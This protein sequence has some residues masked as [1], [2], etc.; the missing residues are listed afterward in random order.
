MQKPKATTTEMKDD[1]KI[2][3]SPRPL[4]PQPR[5]IMLRP[6]L[7]IQR[8]NP[9]Y[10]ISQSEKTKAEKSTHKWNINV[11][12]LEDSSTIFPIER[13]HVILKNISAS[14]VAD[15]VTVC[16]E[17]NSI[18]A[19]FYDDEAM[20]VAETED[21]TRFEIRLLKHQT[22]DKKDNLLLE[23]QRKSGSTITFHWAA[24]SILKS[25]QGIAVKETVPRPLAVSLIPLPLPEGKYREQIAV[26]KE[27]ENIE[28]LLQKD[29]LDANVLGMESLR[30]LTS[31]LS[32]SAK[33]AEI[34]SR[35]I[36]YNEEGNPM[37]GN[38]LKSFMQ[39]R[40]HIKDDEC[41]TQRN[42]ERI[43][44]SHALA[45]F[46]NSLETISTIRDA[47][48]MEPDTWLSEELLPLLLR[49]I[50]CA[51]RPHDAFKAARC[52]HAL[53]GAS[54]DCRVEAFNTGVLSTTF[55]MTK[56]GTC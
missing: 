50:Q 29:R 42:F 6:V 17:E 54:V 25:A 33:N 56:N 26:S 9:K 31:L 47:P 35:S 15:R 38:K 46:A 3:T 48:V 40:H 21:H 11:Q 24:R 16:L 32:T 22:E 12:T 2:S 45:V 20:A 19:T 44:Y 14:V 55:D 23:V 41:D 43:I 34:I 51:E 37:I 52:L 39:T 30:S 10:N 28:S 36:F 27:I 13:T 4:K 1:A 8:E 5:S 7:S 18:F 53:V 49:E